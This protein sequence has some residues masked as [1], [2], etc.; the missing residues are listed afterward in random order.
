M[1]RCQV[2]VDLP[3]EREERAKRDDDDKEFD[4]GGWECIFS[5]DEEVT[6]P[7]YTGMQLELVGTPALPPS[8]KPKRRAK[9]P[10]PAKLESAAGKEEAL[11]E[12]L[13]R[14]AEALTTTKKGG[15]SRV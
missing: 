13:V 14:E 6:L 12:A 3:L 9:Q 5:G 4:T 10:A 1:D 8:P 2:V 15:S 11:T 7:A